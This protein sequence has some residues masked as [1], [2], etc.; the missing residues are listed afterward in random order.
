MYTIDARPARLVAVLALSCALAGAG[1]LHETPAE[2]VLP[3][4]TLPAVT[5]RPPA[6]ELARR[7]AIGEAS[8][9]YGIEA[10]LA[11]RIYDAAVEEG[12]DPELAFALVR[13]ESR[14]E[15]E[16]VGP[17]GA[18]GLAQVMPATARDLDRSIERSDLVK[19]EINL[20]LGFRHLRW[21]LDRYEGDH[22]LALTAYNRGHGTVDRARRAGRDPLNGYAT[23]VFRER[24][25]RL[26]QGAE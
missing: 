5:V 26:F 22:E 8:E 15:P 20:R 14:F 23:R 3:P 1:I 9:H 10:E 21:L 12:I 25:P 18:V 13:V 4:E 11:E 6:G 16:A 2:E 19:P 17:A 24:T 7:R